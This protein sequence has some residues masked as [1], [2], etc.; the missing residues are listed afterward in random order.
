MQAM[1][2]W[3][4]LSLDHKA[5]E[6]GSADLPCGSPIIISSYSCVGVFTEGTHLTFIF[7]IATWDLLKIYKIYI[8]SLDRWTERRYL[9]GSWNFSQTWA[10][11]VKFD[12][13][14]FLRSFW[15]Q[16][17]ILFINYCMKNEANR[18]S[19]L[20]EFS[21]LKAHRGSSLWGFT[22]A[23]VLRG[24]LSNLFFFLYICV[25]QWSNVREKTLEMIPV[26]HLCMK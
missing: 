22:V 19:F 18:G 9:K 2:A 1:P 25:N 21:T 16:L 24:I 10:H 4:P 11:V 14:F 23:R 5:A 20:W 26:S 7:I 13:K 17:M 12:Q 3:L 15:G 6:I 8:F